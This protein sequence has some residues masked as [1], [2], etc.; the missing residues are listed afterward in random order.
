MLDTGRSL[1][2]TKDMPTLSKYL[3]KNAALTPL[4][5]VYVFSP[6][7]ASALFVPKVGIKLLKISANIIDTGQALT[8]EL[9]LNHIFNTW[10]LFSLSAKYCPLLL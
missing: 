6:N 4:H 2:G 8:N 7:W 5:G 3:W 9:M 1:A 10:C